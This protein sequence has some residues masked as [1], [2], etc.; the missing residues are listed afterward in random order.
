M[1]PVEGTVRR[2]ETL[3]P[4]RAGRQQQI[5]TVSDNKIF[6]V[7]VQIQNTFGHNNQFIIG[8]LKILML[9]FRGRRF[10]FAG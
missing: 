4:R 5:F 3:T 10:K 2:L 7:V 6:V 8:Q 9:P 1:E